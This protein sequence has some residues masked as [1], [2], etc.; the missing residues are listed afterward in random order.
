MV[1]R[2]LGDAESIGAEGRVADIDKIDEIEQL[3]QLLGV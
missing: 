3:T 1:K 2:F